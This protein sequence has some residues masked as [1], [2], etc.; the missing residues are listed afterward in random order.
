MADPSTDRPTDPQAIALGANDEE[1][2]APQQEPTWQQANRIDEQSPLSDKEPV[3]EDW[4][5][6]S[7]SVL[8]A[9]VSRGFNSP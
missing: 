1:E 7:S 3:D 9:R 4:T 5:Q 6:L 8:V 2:P